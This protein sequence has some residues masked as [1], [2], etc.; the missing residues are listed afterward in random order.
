MDIGVDYYPEHWDRADWE[1]HAKLMQEA[2]FT[3]VRLAEFAWHKMEPKEGQYE[4]GWLDDAIAVLRKRNIR[5]ILGTPTASPPPWLVTK[6]PDTLAVNQDG[7]RTEAGGRQ[8]TCFSSPK[9]RDLSRRVVSMMAQH[10]TEHPAVIGWQTDNEIGGPRCWCE[11]CAKAFRE[12]L[13]VRYGTTDKL[14]EAWG[15]VFWGQAYNDWNEIPLPRN[16]HASHGPSILLDHHRF[17][18][19][20]VLS[21]HQMQVDL[22]RK[23]CPRHFIT[24]NCMG[25][26]NVVDYSALA[27]SLDRIA[28]DNYPGNAW[29]SG[30]A[31]GAPAD[32]MRSLKH[33][34]FMVMEQRSGLTG[35]LEMFQSGDRPGQLRLWSYQSVAHGADAVV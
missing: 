35:W 2:G 29:G 17:H 8:H 19:D 1:P 30:I 32:Y 24:H 22:L 31:Q 3:L 25:F 23:Q 20:Q 26:Y 4:F 16:K 21:Y 33:Q 34:P 15:T 9:Y 6:Y 28:W 18:S 27:K 14:N 10:F 7:V 12:W 13:K 11:Q 5:V